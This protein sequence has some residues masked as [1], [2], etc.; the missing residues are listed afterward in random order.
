MQSLFPRYEF[1]KLVA[2]YSADKGIRH[3]STWNLLQV[4][5]VVHLTAKRSL[6]NICDS[7]RS[8]MNYWYHLGFHSVS[9]N[10]LSYALMHRSSEIFEKTF[11]VFLSRIH[12]AY[13]MR[14]DK[15]FKFKNR[16]KTID[17]TLV[18]VCL[19][20]FSWAAFRKAKGG[21][22]LHVMYDNQNYLPEFMIITNGKRHDIKEADKIPIAEKSIYVFDR[23]YF[24][25]DF[26]RK[27]NENRAF[28]V[29]RAKKNTQYR[30]VRRNR[31][32]DECIKADWIVKVTGL[33]SRV[34]S[35]PL[36]IVK[37]YDTER[38]R[39]FSFM[40]NNFSLSAKTIADIYKSR[41]DIELF[42]KWI[43]QNL[44]VKTFLGTSENA[45][46]IQIWTA[47]LLFL[48][49]E[50]IRFI[51][52]TSFPLVRVYRYLSDNAFH[53]YN[54]FCLLRDHLFPERREPNVDTGQ[55]ILSF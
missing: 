55:L 19:S 8:K 28:Y 44:K 12:K 30:V 27:I 18:S 7:M 9:R 22:R 26:M 41:W 21:I 2:D 15:R 16:L 40:T 25:Y 48:L 46:R 43:K 4:M 10:N 52:K 23:G 5:L 51:S 1:E 33:K 49:V 11:Y 14:K 17:S 20:M 31:N 3:F 47:L 13:G 34:Y 6:R 32:H 24:C 39:T 38:K 45:V 36:R 35:E 54:L 29:T 42:F 50:Y 37:F 53:N